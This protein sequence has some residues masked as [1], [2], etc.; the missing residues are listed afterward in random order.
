MMQTNKQYIQRTILRMRSF[1][2]LTPFQ[3]LA[4]IKLEMR[5][6]IL[7]D[8]ISLEES[9]L[10]ESLD[11]ILSKK[12]VQIPMLITQTLNLIH[13]YIQQRG[14]KTDNIDFREYLNKLQ[15]L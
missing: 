14:E 15:N 4:I 2:R 12:D 13:S 1:Q 10:K 7:D 8:N 9:K 6:G 5:I 11:F 3:E